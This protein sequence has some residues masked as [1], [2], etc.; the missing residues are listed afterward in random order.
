MNF[1]RQSVNHVIAGVPFLL[2]HRVRSIFAR[3]SK[4]LE[5]PFAEAECGYGEAPSFASVEI[6][7]DEPGS[8]LLY[9]DTVAYPPP[10]RLGYGPSTDPYP[11]RLVNRDSRGPGEIGAQDFAEKVLRLCV[12]SR[13]DRTNGER[14]CPNAST[15]PWSGHFGLLRPHHRSSDGDVAYIEIQ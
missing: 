4:Q 1:P 13:V 14:S 5:N 2:R 12:R 9:G 11:A 3:N 8:F 15:L 6:L 10:E 7:Q